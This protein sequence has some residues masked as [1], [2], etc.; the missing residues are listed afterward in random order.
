MGVL[1]GSMGCLDFPSSSS[2]LVW[3]W[4]SRDRMGNDGEKKQNDPR[5]SCL[6]L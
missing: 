5:R 6:S 3:D 2:D 4:T 1:W